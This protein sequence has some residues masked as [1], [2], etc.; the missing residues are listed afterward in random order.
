LPNLWKD[1]KYLKENY[2]IFSK[3]I[4]VQNSIQYKQS[5]F[6]SLKQSEKDVS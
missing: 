1:E 4:D 5:P 6:E 2:F 3:T